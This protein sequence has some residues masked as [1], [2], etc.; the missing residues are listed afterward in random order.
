MIG[1]SWGGFNA[2][3]VAARRPPALKAII[4]LC[5]TDDRYADDVHYMGGACWQRHAALGDVHAAG[6]AEPPDPA[7]VGER[8]REMWLERI[9]ADEPLVAPGSSTSAATPTGSTARSARTTPRSS[10]AVYAV[11]GWEDG[12]TNAV[13][14]LLEGLPARA[15]A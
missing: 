7:I 15:R 5:S 6:N 12:Y 9:E 2:L 11:G 3:Q 14:R 4:T 13:L 10:C 8:W 1:I